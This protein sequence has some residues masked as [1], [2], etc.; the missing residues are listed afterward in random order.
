MAES[1]E[2]I[3]VGGETNW[4]MILGILTGLVIAGVVIFSTIGG[5]I[6]DIFGGETRNCIKR[7]TGGAFGDVPKKPSCSDT[8]ETPLK[9][10]VNGKTILGGKKI[11]YSLVPCYISGDDTPYGCS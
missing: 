4:V 2:Q 1:I 3:K 6:G 10:I 8:S 7:A 5:D 9:T 11:P